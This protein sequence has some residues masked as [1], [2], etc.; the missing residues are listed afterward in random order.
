MKKKKVVAYILAATMAMNVGTVAVFA[1]EDNQEYS[2]NQEE[3]E[4]QRIELKGANGETIK[5]V[6]PV[7]SL[8]QT[9]QSI[10]DMLQD[11]KIKEYYKDGSESDWDDAEYYSAKVTDEN[12]E[13]VSPWKESDYDLVIPTVMPKGKYW[14]YLK[15]DGS[16]YKALEF[17]ICNLDECDTKELKPDSTVTIENPFF[18]GQNSVVK[19]NVS[20]KAVYEFE[21]D[22][23]RVKRLN[24]RDSEGNDAI[25]Y[26]IMNFEDNKLEC[27][28]TP[29]NYYVSGNDSFQLSM[30]KKVIDKIEVAHVPDV[31]DTVFLQ[32]Q[33]V[34]MRDFIG[35]NTS[36]REGIRYKV[37]YKDNTSE[38]MNY[39]QFKDMA[40]I[41]AKS[42]I[43]RADG[44]EF[45][46]GDN[47]LGVY[48]DTLTFDSEKFTE[49]NPL[50]K[51]PFYIG[52]K[53]KDVPETRWD[54][55]Y[56]VKISAAEIMS[57]MREGE[58]DSTGTLAR[59]QFAMTLYRMS[60]SPD[61]EYSAKFKDIADG[62]WYTKAILWASQA[63]VANGYANGNF[64]PADNINREQ[65]ATMMYNY[66]KNEGYD[67]S[68]RKNLGSFADGRYVSAYAK[69]AMEW[70]VA[71]SIISGKDNGTRLDPQGSA[72][73]GECAAILIRFLEKYVY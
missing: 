60:G 26:Y 58:F 42:N 48:Y 55:P 24:I 49:D 22:Q 59:A 35:W 43:V 61:V 34:D 4:I 3:K 57:G 16:Y 10:H 9:N 23:E 38:E 12:G 15:I 64:G 31:R 46:W 14:L 1:E 5:N 33:I 45:D 21:V 37:S 44:K 30:K 39:S 36:I 56:I 29:G 52:L 54:Y 28:L 27:Y 66:A 70:A 13:Q 62:V 63:G 8:E 67:V 51:I 2:L 69:K 18:E 41:Y 73:R 25:S 19:I 50:I 40:N 6:F 11:M 32:E 47:D 20:E 72:N 17:E 71:N 7:G 65:M 68:A 53:F